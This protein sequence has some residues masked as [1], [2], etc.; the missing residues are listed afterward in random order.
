MDDCSSTEV[1]QGKSDVRDGDSCKKFAVESGL[2]WKI[3]IDFI[4]DPSYMTNYE[5][6]FCFFYPFFEEEFIFS[7]TWLKYQEIHS[8]LDDLDWTTI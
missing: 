1:R 5:L 6:L 4:R 7:R 2:H 8:I 3:S